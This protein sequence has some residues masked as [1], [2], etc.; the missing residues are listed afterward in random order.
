MKRNMLTLKDKKYMKNLRGII[1]K[2]LKGYI[3]GGDKENIHCYENSS[4]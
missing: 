3:Y 4:K 2:I 1:W